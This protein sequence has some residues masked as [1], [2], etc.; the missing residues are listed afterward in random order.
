LLESFCHGGSGVNSYHRLNYLGALE[1]G[2]HLIK[3]ADFLTDPPVVT[4][5]DVIKDLFSILVVLPGFVRFIY[6]LFVGL[7]ED[8]V[9]CFVDDFCCG[10]RVSPLKIGPR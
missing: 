4:V 6:L 2:L 8:G 10:L 7:L 3:L 5:L 9:A 1:D